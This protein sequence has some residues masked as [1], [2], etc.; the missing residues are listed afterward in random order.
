MSLGDSGVLPES[1]ESIEGA[2]VCCEPEE[3]EVL[4]PSAVDSTGVCVEVLDASVRSV[5]GTEVEG[6]EDE[7]EAV[8]VCGVSGGVGVGVGVSGA[9]TS[10][11]ATGRT[12]LGSGSTSFGAGPDVSPPWTTVW[13]PPPPDGPSPPDV[14]GADE[15]E[16]SPESAEKIES[17]ENFENFENAE[18]AESVD[19]RENASESRP[20]NNDALS[21]VNP[22]PPPG[23]PPGPSKNDFSFPR[24]VLIDFGIDA[25]SIF[26]AFAFCPAQPAAPNAAP[27][28]AVSHVK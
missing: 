19:A 14:E 18:S 5:S 15:D 16:E 11:D 21:A 28:V 13:R 22:P 8:A 6:D 17:V 2:G 7:A 4:P 1:T 12:T 23:P 24:P 25:G 9:R 26:T 10:W 27:D 3:C 20:R